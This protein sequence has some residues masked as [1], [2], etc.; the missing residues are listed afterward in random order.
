MRKEI[1][2]RM[3]LA[4][5]M[6][7]CRLGE[8]HGACC[9]HG[10]W[11]SADEKEIILAHVHDVAAVMPDYLR[12]PDLWFDGRSEGDD[13]LPGGVAF[14]TTVLHDPVHHGGTACIFMLPDA[15]CALQAAAMEN[16]LHPWAWKPFYC[17]LHPLDLDEQGRI[18]L[19]ETDEL[20]AEPGS[21]LRPA[22]REIPL[23]ETFQPELEYL[24][25]PEGYRRLIEGENVG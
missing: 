21:C 18:T 17:V 10:V 1:N 4:E 6:R 3:L 14:H 23:L 25:G 22:E 12:E 2:P 5:K 9:L 13:H 15:R 7:R 24:L 11:V 8:C 16:G 20:L 19:D